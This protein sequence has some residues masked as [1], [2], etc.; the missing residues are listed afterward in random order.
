LDADNARLDR[1][2]RFHAACTLVILGIAYALSRALLNSATRPSIVAALT[3]SAMFIIGG[4]MFR[5]ILVMSISSRRQQNNPALARQIG[6]M[7]ITFIVAGIM[8]PLAVLIITAIRGDADYML[9]GVMLGCQLL[10]AVNYY[11]SIYMF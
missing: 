8:L 11:Q 6:I 3:A 9:F 1:M 7:I 5:Q 2:D 4:L 10:G